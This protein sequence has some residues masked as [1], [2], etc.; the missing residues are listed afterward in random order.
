MR[1]AHETRGTSTEDLPFNTSSRTYAGSGFFELFISRGAGE[2][3]LWLHV[4]ERRL[5]LHPLEASAIVSQKIVYACD[6]CIC[7]REQ[8]DANNVRVCD[9]SH[10][11]RG[12]SKVALGAA[13]D[14]D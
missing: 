6:F 12:S 9:V 10:L 5:T 3:L 8:R 2:K 4:C 1:R 13:R 14:E 7:P 11:S